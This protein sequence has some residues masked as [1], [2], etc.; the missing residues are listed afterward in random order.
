M[1]PDELRNHIIATADELYYARGIQTVG[2]DE[3]RQASGLSL[4]KLYSIFPSKESIVLE[5]MRYRHQLWTTGVEGAVEKV[6]VPVDRLLAIYDYLAEWFDTD[7]FRGCG[8][9]NAFGELGAVSPQIAATARTHKQQFQDYVGHLVDEVGGTPELAAQLAI[10][11]EGAQ[12]TAAISGQSSAAGSARRA[13]RTL[14]SVNT[15]TPV[16]AVEV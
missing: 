14:I 10:L 2:M 15:G 1:N 11:A 9:I 12:T 16:D 13:A 3:L 6:S 4:K 5:V 7:S 8:F